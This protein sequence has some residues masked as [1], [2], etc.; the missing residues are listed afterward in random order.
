MNDKD[1]MKIAQDFI[2]LHKEKTQLNWIGDLLETYHKMED[3][4][5]G[6]SHEEDGKFWIEI[7]K[8]ESDSGIPVIF[9]WISV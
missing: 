6:D 9:D 2:S 4:T 3:G 7:G 1:R 5:Y 8:L